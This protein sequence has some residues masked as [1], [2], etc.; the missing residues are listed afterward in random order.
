MYSINMR[1]QKA[2]Y[3]IA[4]SIIFIFAIEEI[5]GDSTPS[6][7][8]S[9][10]RRQYQSNYDNNERIESISQ[11][12]VGNNDRS[13]LRRR[14]QANNNNQQPQPQSHQHRSLANYAADFFRQHF[15]NNI[16]KIKFLSSRPRPTSQDDIMNQY[17]NGVPTRKPT[18]I[19]T[20]KPTRKDIGGIR[21]WPP[22]GPT[23]PITTNDDGGGAGGDDN[24]N[25]E[26]TTTVDTSYRVVLTSR[27]P[28]TPHTLRKCNKRRHGNIA[29]LGIQDIGLECR[30]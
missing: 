30:G 3:I 7:A 13:L 18:P 22:L 6:T 9:L 12:V 19:L 29:C 17:N 8:S 10:L 16:K 27:P 21:P 2:T 23:K 26:T 5:A 24:D 15:G 4:A 14:H 25:E 11:S 20:A 1:F 28:V